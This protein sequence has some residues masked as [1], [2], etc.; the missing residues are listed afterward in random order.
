MCIFTW[1][2]TLDHS[3]PLRYDYVDGRWIYHR[4]GREMKTML[5]EELSTLCNMDVTLGD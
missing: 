3:G 4:D 2:P 1:W 5:Q